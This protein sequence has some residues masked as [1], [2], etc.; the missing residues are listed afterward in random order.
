MSGRFDTC[1]RFT[2]VI[3]GKDRADYL[4]HTLRTCTMQRYDP[5]EIIVSDDG[6]TD[7]TRAVVEEASRRDPRI[8]LI[9]H[10]RSIGMRDNFEFAL[11]EAKPGFVIM[12]GSDD[13]LL[14][15]GIT[16]MRDVLRDTGTELLA[17]PAPVYTYPGV[18]GTNGQLLIYNRKGTRLVESSTFLERQSRNLHYLS[19]LESPMLYVKGVASTRLI[20]QVRGRSPD[21]RFYA[22][23]TPDGYS[24]IVLAGEVERYAFSSRPF[25]LYGLSPSSQGLAYLS[26]APNA[27]EASA[28]FYK[29]AAAVP[30]HR[31]LS[32]LPYSP[33]ITL[34]TADYLLR[35]RDLKG[36]PGRF[37]QIDYRRMLTKSIAELSHGLY[38]GDRIC[39]ELA[40]LNRIADQHGLGH[41]FRETVRRA[42]RKPPKAQFA[43]SGIGPKA[44][45][46][47]ATTLRIR[48]IFDAAYAAHNYYEL[49]ANGSPE[50][51]LAAVSNSVKYR[52]ASL[53]RGAPFPQEAE[54]ISVDP[55]AI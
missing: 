2:V 3:P 19:D 51:I 47:D 10:D 27:K 23:A 15:D 44:F 50:S 35:A 54:W 49:I 8:R 11:Q 40:I 16:G 43:G 7:S 4:A 13:G 9:A 33:L 31:E 14:P 52:L 36:W 38:G 21:R 12:L 46:F 26:N 29:S 18:R 28:A 5:L 24:G 37:P 20:D 30:L 42:R 25:S 53:G 34:M 41:L 48:D 1:P 39:R 55:T 6:S 22:C 45:Y 32:S 17:W